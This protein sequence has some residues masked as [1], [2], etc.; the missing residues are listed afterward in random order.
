MP[1]YILMLG[2]TE[3]FLKI[4]LY[5]Y[6]HYVYIYSKTPIQCHLKITPI[7]INYQLCQW[8]NLAN[9]NFNVM[10]PLKLQFDIPSNKNLSNKAIFL[11]I[12][13]H[14]KYSLIWKNI[15]NLPYIHRLCE[16]LTGKSSYLL[17]WNSRSHC[18]AFQY[19]GGKRVFIRWEQCRM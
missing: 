10:N 18:N 3:H 4:N 15:P 8:S 17:L 1:C 9:E 5:A 2:S 14:K 6:M 11:E 12:T 19:T 13:C 7:P 16:T